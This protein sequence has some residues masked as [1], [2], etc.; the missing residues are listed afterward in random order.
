M[1]LNATIHKIDLQ[2]SDIDRHYYASHVLT[3]ARHPSETEERLMLRVLAFAL[4][5]HDSLSFGKGLSDVDEPDLWRKDLT[6]AIEQWIEIGQPD[7]QRLR[8]A[9]GR[10]RE[11]C[12]YSYGRAAPVWWEKH[13]D[14]LRR[15]RQ[16]QVVEIDAATCSALAAIAARKLDLQCLIQDGA[17]QLLTTQGSVDVGLQRRLP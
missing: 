1:A 14:A 13:A 17:A 12:V 10:A 6:G 16:L 8:Q 7:E 4:N 3:V 2:V 11:V 5:A 9:A 15:I